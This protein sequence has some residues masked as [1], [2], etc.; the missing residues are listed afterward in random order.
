M[1]TE[2][3]I[4]CDIC[5]KEIKHIRLYQIKYCFGMLKYDVCGNCMTELKRMRY[6]QNG[7]N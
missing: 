6:K 2:I 1:T 5:D 3:K 7:K 4:I